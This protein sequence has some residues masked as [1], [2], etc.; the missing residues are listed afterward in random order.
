[1]RPLVPP[2]SMGEVGA[3]LSISRAFDTTFVGLGAAFAYGIGDVGEVG[4]ATGLTLSPDFDWNRT[5]LLQ[6]HLAP[7]SK[8]FDFAPGLLVPI[9]AVD[10]AGFG[11]VVDL[12][13]RYVLSD[14]LFV[15]F[16]GSAIPIQLSLET[17]GWPSRPTGASATRST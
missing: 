6:D 7:S 10:G 15:R 13:C 11:V 5:L 16:G 12:P 14:G 9:V 2:N 3:D 8:L 17:S 1:M 4:V